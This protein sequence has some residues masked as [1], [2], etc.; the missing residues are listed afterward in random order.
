MVRLKLGLS[1]ARLS[2]VGI[3]TIAD[4]TGSFVAAT[5]ES[6]MRTVAIRRVACLFTLAKMARLCFFCCKDNGCEVGTVFMLA[7]A[8]R[9]VLRKPTRAVSVLLSFDQ[10]DFFWP[11][12]CD[13]GFVHVVS[14]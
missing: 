10:L 11:C 3:G 1:L 9:L 8:K 2:G 13:F 6:L 7:I 14:F 5:I 4:A 12:V